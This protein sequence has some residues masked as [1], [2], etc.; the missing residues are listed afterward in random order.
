MPDSWSERMDSIGA[1]QG[2]ESAQSR[3]WTWQT[4]WNVAL[5]RPLVGAGFRAEALFIFERYAP[6]T[7]A[8]EAFLSAGKSW[9][10]HSI[11]FQML[12]EQGFP[13]LFFFLA[14]WTAVW[15][16]AGRLARKARDIPELA[17]WMPLLLN[18]IQVSLIG[19]AVGGAFLSLAYL[20]LPYYFMAYVVLAD[21]FIA[22]RHA[23]GRAGSPAQAQSPGSMAGNGGARPGLAKGG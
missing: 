23:Q 12:G 1:Y 21:V 22:R 6:T 11:Y 5:D 14:L 13:G 10:A 18:M 17:G 4:L 15:L 2:D 20:D 8:G 16:R 7:G 9:V 3:L 19:Y